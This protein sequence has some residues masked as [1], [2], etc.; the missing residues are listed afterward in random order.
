MSDT[1]SVMA[2]FNVVFALLVSVA[3]V[4]GAGWFRFFHTS[5][6]PTSELALVQTPETRSLNGENTTLS[7][8][9]ANASFQAPEA[10]SQ[11]DI[12]G[13]SIF[14]DYVSLKSSNRLDET[15]FNSLV[16]KY[17]QTILSKDI[18]PNIQFYELNIVTDSSTNAKEYSRKVMEVRS[19][20]ALLI[21][22]SFGSATFT[23]ADDP[24]F[25]K[26][27]EYASD[28][29]KKAS[30]DL[31]EIPVPQS[32]ASNH[33]RLIKNYLSSSVSMAALA[34][35][36]KDPARTYSA[37]NTYA[38]NTKEEA[39]LLSNIQIAMLRNEANFNGGI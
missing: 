39:Q 27:M 4:G 19:K 37:L 31:I 7:D 9:V 1:I 8:L 21:D 5:P 14:S 10:L 28:L 16:S 30:S 20:Y 3:L 15:N 34:D 18:P 38:Q 29:Y 35:I 36:A 25:K 24:N 6:I 22:A 23:D 26:L 32:L 17:T 33:L 2:R 13:R 11:T 12:I